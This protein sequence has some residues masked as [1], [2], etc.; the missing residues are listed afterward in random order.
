M[1]DVGGDCFFDV[2]GC[3]VVVLERF[4]GVEDAREYGVVEPGEVGLVPDVVVGV[5][6]HCATVC[7]GF[8]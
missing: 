6:D 3:W 2:L 8:V 4:V 5:D 7:C 1:F